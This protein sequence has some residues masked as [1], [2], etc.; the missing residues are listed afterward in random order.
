[1]DL[2]GGP[3][4][5]EA[6]R[7]LLAPA[8]ERIVALRGHRT[9]AHAVLAGVSGID[10]SGKGYLASRLA[11]LLEARGLRVALLNVD[12]W[13]N[14]P[15][16]RFCIIKPGEHF[17]RHGLRLDE[18]FEQLV[19]PLRVQR[20]INLEMDHAEETARQYRRQRFEFHAVDVVLVEGIFIFKREF[21]PR[22][23]LA[24]WIDCSF[25]TAMERAI[26]RGQEGLPPAETIRAFETIY[27][28]AQR[29]HFE[30]D[31]PQ[32]AADLTLVNDPRCATHGAELAHDGGC[33]QPPR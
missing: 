3:F 17:Y 21:R 1:M 9:S 28:P 16:V 22:F 14:L 11:R 18:M 30:R 12:G 7:A 26:G 32:S 23:D 2:P 29:V 15:H 27:W 6:E 10:A 19:L 8:V 31:E 33:A 5:N 20:S 4:A 25:V 13:L 24:C